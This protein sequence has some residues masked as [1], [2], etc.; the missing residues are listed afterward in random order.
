MVRSIPIC[1][2]LGC[3]AEVDAPGTIRVHG[4]FFS[5]GSRRFVG[6]GLNLFERDAVTAPGKPPLCE[7]VILQIFDVTQDRLTRIEA[8][9]APGFLR[10][11]IQTLFDVGGKRSASISASFSTL[12]MYTR[13]EIV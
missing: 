9:G 13:P 6:L 7:V 3:R 11:G 4:G 2:R 1:N 12:Y 5:A 8:L 10:Q